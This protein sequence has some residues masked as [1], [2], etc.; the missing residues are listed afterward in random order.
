M[1][2]R[3]GLVRKDGL[4][5]EEETGLFDQIDEDG[6]GTIELEELRNA[7]VKLDFPY[8][9]IAEVFRSFDVD[10]SGTIEREEWTDGIQRGLLSDALGADSEEALR[11]EDMTF[12]RDALV[13]CGFG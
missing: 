8:A 13:I 3:D 12:C 1:E 2:E 10:G 4:T 9:S 5:V 6:S 7:L 11:G